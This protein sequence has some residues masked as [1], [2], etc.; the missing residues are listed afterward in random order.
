MARSQFIET[1]RKQLRARHYSIQ[2]EKV[3]L[4]WIRDYIRFCNYRH[5]DETGNTEIEEFL[6][7]LANSRKVSA[8]TQN[9]AL[10]ALIFMFRHILDKEIEGLSYS[11]TKREV[12]MPTVLDA[13]E[14]STII[15]NMTGKYQLIASLLYGSGLRINEALKLRVQDLNFD[16][17]TILVFRGKG[18]KDRYTILP[19]SLI[20]SLR[21]QIEAA[22]CVHFKDLEDGEGF[23]SVGP[24]LK[25][26]YGSALKDFH[27]QFLFPSSVRC[28]HPYD[29]YVCRHHIHETA[30]RKQLRKAVLASQITKRV[31][32]HTFRHSFA[33][34]LLHM[35]T[36]IRTVQDLL[37]HSDLKTTEIYTHVLGSRFGFTRSPV[38]LANLNKP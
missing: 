25:K 6:S 28:V 1:I 22:R 20:P 15:S 26:K 9:Q 31:T 36:D 7:H 38:D 18:K 5:P 8:A 29:G 16:N 35:G 37:G 17:K 21:N 34:Q 32:A 23:S 14:A 33:T 3:Y 2:T 4:A 27:W 24:G 10:C 13:V 11:F 19:E 30:F 12:R